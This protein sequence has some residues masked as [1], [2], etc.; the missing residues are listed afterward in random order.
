MERIVDV[1]EFLVFDEH[2]F[3]FF[4]LLKTSGCHC[5]DSPSLQ[6]IA[7]LR[8]FDYHYSSCKLDFKI[9]RSLLH[10][11]LLLKNE[12]RLL[13]HPCLFYNSKETR[14]QPLNILNFGHMADAFLEEH[15]SKRRAHILDVSFQIDDAIDGSRPQLHRP[16]I[17]D[18]NE[19]VICIPAKLS[20]LQVHG[21]DKPIFVLSQHKP[22]ILIYL[23]VSVLQERVQDI[24]VDY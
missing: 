14:Q 1:S 9:P 19:L 23:F 21:E 11:T 22:I 7:H 3:Y 13:L 6:Q 5:V 10:L 15:P 8:L 20:Q 24:V 17:R 12:P 16:D 18:E 4:L 2:F